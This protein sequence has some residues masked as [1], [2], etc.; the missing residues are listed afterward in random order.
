M[1]GPIVDE[2]H[3]E[4]EGKAVVGK[5]DVDN[6]PE[7]AQKYGIRNI[8]TI[9]FI[10]DGEVV[11]IKDGVACRLDFE[12]SFPVSVCI[13]DGEDSTS[14]LPENAGEQ[15]D[16]EDIQFDDEIEEPNDDIVELEDIVAEEKTDGSLI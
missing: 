12:V 1:V 7:V 8:P 6:N 3:T 10:K 16:L 15:F 2:I 14:S 11:V 5:V 4:Y 9:L 13:T